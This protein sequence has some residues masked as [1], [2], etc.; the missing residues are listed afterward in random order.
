MIWTCTKKS[1]I[2]W[3]IKKQQAGPQDGKKKTATLSNSSQPIPNTSCVLF[4]LLSSRVCPNYCFGINFASRW[5]QI[6]PA[7]I[8]RGG[9]FCD[10]LLEFIKRVILFSSLNFLSCITIITP[11][12]FLLN[13]W[14]S[15][16]ASY[17]CFFV[18]FKAYRRRWQLS[19]GTL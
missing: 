10:A 12:S 1:F 5:N 11:F 14:T 9:C 7:R 3:H 17:W 6:L 15:A 18:L 16:A 2:F 4:S 13:Y 8:S 19:P